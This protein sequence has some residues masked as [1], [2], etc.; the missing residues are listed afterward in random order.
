MGKKRPNKKKRIK[1]Q[2]SAQPG[3][4]DTAGVSFHPADLEGEEASTAAPQEGGA[5]PLGLPI[6]AK[7]YEKLQKQARHR[8]LP[9]H[10]SSQED[11][12]APSG[13]G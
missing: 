2:P 1:D 3:G 13:D 6:S 9:P 11:P 8:Q 12:A 4:G 10:G 5:I 7:E